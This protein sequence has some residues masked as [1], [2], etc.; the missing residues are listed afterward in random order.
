MK[1][2]FYLFSNE[3]GWHWRYFARTAYIVARS[4]QP[5]PTQAACEAAIEEMRGLGLVGI[6]HTP[7]ST[8]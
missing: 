5:Y 8:S 1:P 6:T 7:Q 3:E 2:Y 4:D